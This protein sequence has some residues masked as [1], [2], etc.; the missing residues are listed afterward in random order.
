[1]R[2][3]EVKDFINEYENECSDFLTEMTINPWKY[4]IGSSAINEIVD[5]FKVSKNNMHF[6]KNL[7]YCSKEQRDI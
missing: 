7:R 6:V 5:Y 1:M 2:I 3:Q 4:I